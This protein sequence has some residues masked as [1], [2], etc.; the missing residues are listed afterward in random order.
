VAENYREL[1][2]ERVLVLFRRCGRGKR[3]GLDVEQMRAR[4]ATLFHISRGKVKR[5]VVYHDDER[6]LA[7]F[8]LSSEAS[9]SGL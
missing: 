5:L 9:S 3:S 1:D 4:G 8:G 6:A 2:G 7:D